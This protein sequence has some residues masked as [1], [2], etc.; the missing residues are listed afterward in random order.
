MVSFAQLGAHYAA[1]YVRYSAQFVVWLAV[2]TVALSA[3]GYRAREFI[4]SFILLYLLS[5]VIFAIGQWD[6][7]STYNL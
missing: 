6:K 5:V 4:P 3:L 1:N 2:F 7:A